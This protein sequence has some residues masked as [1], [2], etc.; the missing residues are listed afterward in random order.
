M[1]ILLLLLLLLII[2]YTNT[3]SIHCPEDNVY[4]IIVTKPLRESSS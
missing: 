4:G 1:L 2:I 3:K